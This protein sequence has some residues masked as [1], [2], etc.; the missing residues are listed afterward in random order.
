[1]LEYKLGDCIMIFSKLDQDSRILGGNVFKFEIELPNR[2]IE[3]EDLS[4]MASIINA[5]CVRQKIKVLTC[6]INP[7]FYKQLFLQ[8]NNF[9]FIESILS[10]RRSLES[11]DE[12]ILDIQSEVI[13]RKCRTTEIMIVEEMAKRIFVY[14]RFSWD[15]R[16]KHNYSGDRYEDW[17][18]TAV[19]VEKYEL[20][21]AQI[22]EEIIGFFI[23]EN[24]KDSTIYWH[25]TGIDERFQGKGI[26][27][28]VWAG[29]L[30]YF[31]SLGFTHVET[32]ISSNNLAT[33]NLYR[34]LN[35]HFGKLSYTFHRI[36]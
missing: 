29:A 36:N 3:L 26:G 30:R 31:H 35:F 19:Q 12:V 7:D 1:M 15:K 22:M 10:P 2:F 21:V 13:F 6:R 23:V 8:F 14:D 5:T 24:V 27:K 25:L 34:H 17:V 33:L 16:M 32:S 20:Y 11:I 18:K 4:I 28:K 9:V